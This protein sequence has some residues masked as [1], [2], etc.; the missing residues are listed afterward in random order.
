M[1]TKDESW[2]AQYLEQAAGFWNFYKNGV[3]DEAG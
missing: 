2:C 1:I 3:S